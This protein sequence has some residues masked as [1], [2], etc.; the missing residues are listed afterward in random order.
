IAAVA[1]FS[2]LG[3]WSFAYRIMQVPVLLYFSLWRVSY[4]AMSR[5]IGAKEDLRPIIERTIGVVA[6]AMAPIL[7]GI[8][9]SAHAL[10]PPL[11]GDRWSGSIGILVWASAAT[12]VNAPISVPCEGYLLA[13]GQVSKVLLAAVVG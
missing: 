8:V 4:P 10:L 2:T 9:A 13:A 6:V 11:V 7:V 12:M 5:L 3:L 1:G